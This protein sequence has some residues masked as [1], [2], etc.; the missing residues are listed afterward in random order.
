MNVKNIPPTF[1]RLTGV[2]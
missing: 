1:T 2:S